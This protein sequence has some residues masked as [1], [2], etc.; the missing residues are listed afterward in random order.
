MEATSYSFNLFLP[1]LFSLYLNKSEQAKDQL[2]LFLSLT[3]PSAPVD[4]ATQTLLLCNELEFT[5]DGFNSS[6]P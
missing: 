2:L 4:N 1:S 5:C 6:S 3:F